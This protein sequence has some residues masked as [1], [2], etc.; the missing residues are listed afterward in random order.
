[1]RGLRPT[2]PRSKGCFAELRRLSELPLHGARNAVMSFF[3]DHA[4]WL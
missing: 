3:A 4:G 1:M 2:C